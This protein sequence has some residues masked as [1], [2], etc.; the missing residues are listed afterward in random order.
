MIMSS[1]WSRKVSWYW[2]II[3]LPSNIV[4]NHILHQYQLYFSILN[5]IKNISSFPWPAD[6]QMDKCSSVNDVRRLISW[7]EDL[8]ISIIP[9]RTII[10]TAYVPKRR[11]IATLSIILSFLVSSALLS[12]ERYCYDINSSMNMNSRLDKY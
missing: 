7:A 2:N 4:I 10:H 3:Q 6:D 11:A 8:S 5:I 9:I 12:I 1:V